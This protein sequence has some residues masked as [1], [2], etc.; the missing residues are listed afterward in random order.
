MQVYTKYTDFLYHIDCIKQILKVFLHI[1][2][3]GYAVLNMS[4]DSPLGIFVYSCTVH[5]G[6][7]SISCIVRQMV[8]ANEL[9]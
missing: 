2:F 3:V 8:S 4:Q 1:H 7:T 9:H 5:H 6:R